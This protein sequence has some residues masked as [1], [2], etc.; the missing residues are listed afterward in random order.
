MIAP[1]VTIVTPQDEEDARAWTRRIFT[2]LIP[3][4]RANGIG[5]PDP[6][7]AMQGIYEIVT[8]GAAL[9]AEVDGEI[10][11]SLGLYLADIWYAHGTVLRELWFWIRPDL[12]DGAVLQALLAEAAAIADLAGA[13][14]AL[15]INNPNRKRLPRTRLERVADALS[16]QSR[17]AA[18]VIA[19]RIA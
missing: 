1:T 19:P 9:V 11:G 8:G 15:A 10:V 13:H 18:Y 6:G 5:E 16:Y 12:R 4:H 7:K 14:V 3:L 17:G 2:F